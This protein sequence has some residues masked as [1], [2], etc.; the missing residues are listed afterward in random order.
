[1]DFNA[2]IAVA[3][4]VRNDFAFSGGSDSGIGEP[5]FPAPRGGG[6]QKAEQQKQS[7]SAM[8]H[9]SFPHKTTQV[10]DKMLK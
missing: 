9:R 3:I 2:G 1:M 10:R 5:V 4:I 8:A 6:K 7:D